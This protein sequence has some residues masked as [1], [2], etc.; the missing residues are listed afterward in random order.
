[1][2]QEDKMQDRKG[3]GQINRWM[4]WGSF[5]LGLSIVLYLLFFCPEEC[6]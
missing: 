5:I 3:L 4:L 6:H 1:M 2:H